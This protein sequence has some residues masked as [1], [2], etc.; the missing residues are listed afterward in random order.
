MPK[1]KDNVYENM[2]KLSSKLGKQI[3]LIENNCLII[4]E[5]QWNKLKEAGLELDSLYSW[6]TDHKKASN[7]LWKVINEVE[8][9]IK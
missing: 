7:Q 6:N 5:V 2:H 9:G 3:D 1:G 8:G 4:K